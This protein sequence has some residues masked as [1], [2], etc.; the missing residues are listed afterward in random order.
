MARRRLQRRGLLMMRRRGGVVEELL[1]ARPELEQ[2]EE[3]RGR[4]DPT[5]TAPCTLCSQ[6]FFKKYNI[7]SLLE[8]F[9][10]IKGPM[11]IYYFLSKTV[12]HT[13][14]LIFYYYRTLTVG[15]SLIGFIV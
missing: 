3:D 5:V 6:L 14:K 8:I 12:C 15:F 7:L 4:Q 1:I 10:S 11:N 9:L 2:Q 13:V